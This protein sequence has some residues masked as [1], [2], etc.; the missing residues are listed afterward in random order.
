MNLVQLLARTA[1]SR[2]ERAAVAQGAGI[3]MTYRTLARRAA[4]LGAALAER[5]GLRPGD[6]VALAM[7]NGPAYLEVLYGCWWAGLAPVPM[8]AKLHP[9]ELAFMLEASGARL[10]FVSPELAG[11]LGGET[12]GLEALLE[13]VET[14]GPLYESLFRHEETAPAARGM[15]DLAW[16]FFTSGTTGRPKGAQITH[17]N[18]WAMT[19]CYFPDV[20]P[21]APDDAIV[22]AAPM[23]HGAGLY[24][25]PYMAQGALHV[26]PESGGFDPAE[27]YSL[28]EVHGGVGAFF[29]PTMVKRLVEHPGARE[30]AVENLNTLV[31]GGGPMYVADL[32][33]G[34]EVLGNRFVQIYGQ[35]ESPMCITSL[36]RD[37]H[38][39]RDHP[40]YERRLASVGRPQMLVEVRIADE[41]GGI[42]PPGEA[43]EVLVRG[44]SVVPG[45][46]Q[47]PEATAKTVRDGWLHT[48]DVGSLDAEGFLTLKDR[49]KDV[50]ISGGTNIYP[51][52]VEEVLL[53][54]PAVAEAAVV[55]RPHAEWGEEV[56]AVLVPRGTA[57]TPGEL[58][59]LCLE[60]I[61]RFKRPKDY[62]FVESLPKNN[63]GKVLKTELRRML[64]GGEA[65]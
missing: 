10:C 57:P 35:G 8:N 31:Y 50:I 27:F 42:L 6:R 52:E 49:S 21:V 1:R 25:F 47:D 55:G 26:I 12:G 62:R 58:D 45:Y 41:E 36:T 19:S 28:L 38:A 2:G 20:D 51:R 7:K 48:G 40:A 60:R 43:G 56:V 4:C 18:L 63:Y 59:A 14:P 46:W 9:R 22:Y 30:A 64:A 13:L 61:A 54:H 17:G 3:V 32:K 11:G 23:S 33:R 15:D 29:A 34:M 53:T 24:N 16:L 37:M 5:F 65:G 39:E 44:P